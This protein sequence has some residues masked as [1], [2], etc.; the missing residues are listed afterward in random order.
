[1][2]TDSFIVHVETE[3]I[4]EGIS[5][6]VEKKFNTSKYELERLLPKGKKK[7]AIG[8]MKGLMN[9]VEKLRKNLLD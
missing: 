2:D 9:Q 8:L 1:M 5:K 3:D 4:Y 7:K 6:D